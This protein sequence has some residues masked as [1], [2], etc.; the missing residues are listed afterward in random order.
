[1]AFRLSETQKVEN[2]QKLFLK[3]K[4]PVLISKSRPNSQTDQMSN[5]QI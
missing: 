1:M 3:T 5:V 4:I 2:S